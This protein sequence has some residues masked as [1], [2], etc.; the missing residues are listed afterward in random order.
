MSGVISFKIIKHVL[1][2]RIPF[3]GNVLIIL[4]ICRLARLYLFNKYYLGWWK[5]LMFMWHIY[6]ISVNSVLLTDRLTKS[7]CLFVS[8]LSHLYE[9]WT[10]V[11]IMTLLT[12]STVARTYFVLY[13]LFTIMWNRHKLWDGTL[14]KLGMVSHNWQMHA[15]LDSGSPIPFTKHGVSY[16]FACMCK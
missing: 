12:T 13:G 14:Q 6:Q 5:V 8:L 10:L 15:K 4:K 2:F 7:V 16:P 11:F 9:K 3:L 1:N